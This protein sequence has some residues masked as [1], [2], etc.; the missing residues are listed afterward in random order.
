MFIVQFWMD[1]Y[2]DLRIFFY[3]HNL[4]KQHSRCGHSW[5][6]YCMQIQTYVYMCVLFIVYMAIGTNWNGRKVR[7]SLNDITQRI[8]II[9]VVS[10]FISKYPMSAAWKQQQRQEYHGWNNNK[11]MRLV[12]SLAV[13]QL[14]EEPFYCESPRMGVCSSSVDIRT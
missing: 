8:T 11:N 4:V 3:I 9:L 5:F 14:R 10:S 2:Y 12:L 7:K 6:E 13:N 1:S